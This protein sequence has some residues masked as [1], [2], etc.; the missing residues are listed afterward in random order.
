VT[1]INQKAI[2][3]VS[4]IVGAGGN[5]GAVLAGFLF[6][7]SEISYS[8]A[9]MYIGVAIACIAAVVALINF[10]KTQSITA[11]TGQ[12]EPAEA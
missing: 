12:L 11:E 5:V 8:Q 3:S 1:F 2:G 4:G 9:F 7:S 10:E 6:K